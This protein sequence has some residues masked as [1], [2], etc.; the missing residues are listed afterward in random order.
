MYT[1]RIWSLYAYKY[2]TNDLPVAFGNYF[3]KRS[4]IHNYP[5]R[6][7]NVL[8]LTPN[9]KSFPIMVSEQGVPLFGTHC[10]NQ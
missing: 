6:H 10:Q 3:T 1:Y 5:S 7:V 8:N 4:D 9:K 2:S